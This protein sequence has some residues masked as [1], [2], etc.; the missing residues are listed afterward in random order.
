MA[1]I[2]SHRPT[3]LVDRDIAMARTPYE[4][5]IDNVIDHVGTNIWSF[6]KHNGRWFISG[7]A[8]NSRKPE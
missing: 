3:I 6:A 7:V 4:F 2:I 5:S 8:D 1:E